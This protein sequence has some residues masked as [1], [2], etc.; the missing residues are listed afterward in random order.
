MT[1]SPYSLV[2]QSATSFNSRDHERSSRRRWNYVRHGGRPQQSDSEEHCVFW[3]M[4]SQFAPLPIRPS[5]QLAPL[6]YGASWYPVLS[7]FWRLSISTKDSTEYAAIDLCKSFGGAK[8]EGL[9]E[10]LHLGWVGRASWRWGE[11]TGYLLVGFN[12]ILILCTFV[13]Q[14]SKG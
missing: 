5:N 13:S 9:W 8:L 4:Y 2:V 11:V 3:L 1:C 14:P 6:K 12:F 10:T 7:A